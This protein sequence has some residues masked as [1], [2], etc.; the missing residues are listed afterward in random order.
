M[1]KLSTKARYSLR[2]MIELALREGEGPI[3]L[4]EVAKA[5]RIS[6]KYLE[7]L[8]MSLRNAGLVNSARGPHGGYQLSRPA[9]AITALDI[10]GAVEGPLGLLDCIA[11]STTC[12]RADTCAARTLWRRTSEA[13]EEVLAQTSLSELR[14]S[15]RAADRGVDFCYY[16]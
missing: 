6:P 5:Q 14:D 8:A 7:Q 15:Q 10:L 2:A 4:R 13:I 9:E 11:Q 16:I 1:L 3:Q 12:D